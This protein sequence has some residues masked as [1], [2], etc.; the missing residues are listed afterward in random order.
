MIGGRRVL[1]AVTGGVAAF[2]AATLARLLIERDA[3][4][5]A[6]MTVPAR[7]FLGSNT[8]AA[9]TGHPVIVDLFNDAESVSPHTEAA[10]WADLVVVAPATAASVARLAQ[11]LSSDPVTATIMAATCP[12]VV[13][14]AMHTAMWKHP[15]TQRNL[16]TLRSDGVAVLG[17]IVGR[18]AGGDRGPGRMMEPEE[19]LEGIQALFAAP[20]RGVRVLVTAGGTREAIDP[21]RFLS[22]HSSGKMG[23][24]VAAEA[25]RR[26]AE[27]TLV[28]CSPLPSPPAVKRVDVVSAHDMA[29]AVSSIEVDVAVMTAAV[30]DFRPQKS[31]G[32][33]LARS[34]GFNVLE[35]APTRDVLGEV[36]G[37]KTRPRVVVGFAAETGNVE[38]AIGKARK[39]GVDLMVANDVTIPGSGFESDNNQVVLIRRNGEAEPWPLQAKSRVAAGLWDEV[40]RLLEEG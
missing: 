5:R 6:M 40:T 21:V 25:A 4:V 24:A 22:N 19:L 12:V 1:L 30:A 9:I 7:K 34:E 33:K 28:T 36:V 39:K 35:L 15:A 31:H 32:S 18:L 23:H 13:A 10:E 11:G 37:R 3:Q 2:K 26:G 17:P 20:L 27:T 16:D 29:E 14:P 38:R 8:L